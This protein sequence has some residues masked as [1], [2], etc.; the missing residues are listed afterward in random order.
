MYRIMVSAVKTILLMVYLRSVRMIFYTK[1]SYLRE[2][3]ISCCRLW[4]SDPECSLIGGDCLKS[5]KSS[6]ADS[7][8]GI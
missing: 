7:G 3:P 8:D 6:M 5:A 2:N 4:S 1:S